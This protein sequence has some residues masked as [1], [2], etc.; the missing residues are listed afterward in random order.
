MLEG[1]LK[2]W[3]DE[4]ATAAWLNEVCRPWFSARL[5]DLVVFAL[6]AVN[7]SVYCADLSS[8]HLLSRHSLRWY[9]VTEGLSADR[10]IICVVHWALTKCRTLKTRLFSGCRVKQIIAEKTESSRPLCSLNLSFMLV[11]LFLSELSV[12]V[13]TV[14]YYFLFIVQPVATSARFSYWG[15]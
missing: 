1:T 10:R 8:C 12:I 15:L 13:G 7:R 9:G 5:E 11:A 2:G 14:V 3:R 6:T 4:A